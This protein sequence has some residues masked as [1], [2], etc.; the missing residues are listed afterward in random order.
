AQEASVR[1]SAIAPKPSELLETIDLSLPHLRHPELGLLAVSTPDFD[2]AGIHQTGQKPDT[3]G[4]APP[5]VALRVVDAEGRPL[6]PDEEGRLQALV[7]DRDGWIDTGHRAGIDR[8]GFVRVRS[9]GP[10]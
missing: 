3:V 5:G 8:D 10:F 7:P 4:Q 2:R 9:E 1:T 6:P